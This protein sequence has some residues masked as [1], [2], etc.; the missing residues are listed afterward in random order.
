MAAITQSPPAEAAKRK[1]EVD[2]VIRWIAVIASVISV[3]AFFYFQALGVTLSYKDAISHLDIARRVIDSPTTGLAQL[4]GVW[5]PLPHIL[6]MP[7]IW[8]DA[9]YYSGFAGSIVSMLAYVGTSVLLYKIVYSLTNHQ[10]ASV[11]AA[12]IFMTNPNVLYMQSTPMTELLLFACMAGMVYGMQ[13]WA[14]TDQSKYLVGAAV[15][16]LMGT[17]TRYE[18]W[19]LLAVMTVLVVYIAWRK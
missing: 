14:I 2:H 5:L 7:F 13:Q 6:A 16:G 19:V 18:A 11:V 3:I 9:L 15:A 4:G 17:M 10:L 12:T 8:I 1:K